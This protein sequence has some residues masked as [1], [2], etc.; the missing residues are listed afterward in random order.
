[1]KINIQICALLLS[2]NLITSCNG[3][4]KTD[5]QKD[6]VSEQETIVGGQPK[7]IRTQGIVSGNLHCN[8]QDKAG[9]IDYNV[10]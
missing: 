3:Q 8:L 10:R 2:F 9:N 5:I 6:S 1:M 7:I 4:V